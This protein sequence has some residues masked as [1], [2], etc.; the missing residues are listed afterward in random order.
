M[1][2]KQLEKYI[3]LFPRSLIARAYRLGRKQMSLEIF[4]AKN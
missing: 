3:R 4:A 1:T 2:D